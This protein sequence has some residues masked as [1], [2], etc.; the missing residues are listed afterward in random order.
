MWLKRKSQGFLGKG[1][2][3]PQGK[4]LQ[5]CCGVA[6]KFNPGKLWTAGCRIFK[7]RKDLYSKHNGHQR[8]PEDGRPASQAMHQKFKC[9]RRT[10][11]HQIFSSLEP[12]LGSHACTGRR[13]SGAGVPAELLLNFGAAFRMTIA[14][15]PYTLHIP[16]HCRTLRPKPNTLLQ[17][18]SHH[19]VDPNNASACNWALQVLAA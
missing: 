12:S 14:P 2:R 9:F 6:V 4:P 13:Q 17:T 8:S 5:S 10:I 3:G 15:K 18:L 19:D 1:N 16:T 7:L 11:H